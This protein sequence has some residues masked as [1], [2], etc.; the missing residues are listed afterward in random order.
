MKRA[1]PT[2]AEYAV[3][4]IAA[5]GIRHVFGLPGDF[6]FPINDAIKDHPSLDWTL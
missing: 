1:N 3:D 2:V 6:S 5:L 4:R